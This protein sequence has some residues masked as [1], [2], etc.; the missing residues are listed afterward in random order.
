MTAP[1]SLL[2]LTVLWAIIY[3]PG[4]GD[5][6][7][8]GEEWR[9]TLLGRNMLQNGDWLVPRSGGMPYVAKPPLINW[10][11]AAS[12][13]L[14]GIQNEWTA[15]LPSVLLILSAILGVYAVSRRFMGNNAAFVGSLMFMTSVGVLEKS[16]IAELE[17]YY[18]AFTALAFVF[19][20]AG[21]TG[22]MNRWMGWGT[23]GLFLGL[24][25]ITKGPAHLLFFYLPVVGACWITRRWRELVS[26]PH[27]LGLAI[28]F[29][30]TLA[31]AIPFMEAYGRLRGIPQEAV[32]DAWKQQ[33]ASRV[34]GE[35]KSS[36]SDWIQRGPRALVMFLPWV[37]LVPLCWKRSARQTA[38]PAEPE[39]RIF[40]GLCWGITASFALMILIPSSSARYV[41]PLLGPVALLTGWIFTRA[42]PSIRL[43]KSGA[44]IESSRFVLRACTIIAAFMVTFVLIAHPIMSKKENIRPLGT[45]INEALEPKDAPLYIF[46][47]GQNPYP[48]Y[49][50]ADTV[51]VARVEEMPR[52]GVRWLLLMEEDDRFLPGFE[53]LYG[54]AETKGQFKTTWGA[55]DKQ[56]KPLRLL[57]FPGVPNGVVQ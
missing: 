34:T 57:R 14:T 37:L 6:E 36:L 11:S 30:I 25:F 42:Y 29:G 43:K 17:V 38:F 7:I 21:F 41:A 35:E 52:Q 50:P 16:R 18:I 53:A 5:L 22:K 55:E 27:L 54:P 44:Q 19:W 13:K 46:H 56:G 12:F 49:L 26:L 10:V 45:A 51:E 47:F 23:A 2:I 20:L 4:L 8:K 31:W 24:A 9:R 28:C 48:F 15:R 32:L 33:V 39:R 1:R 3:L 40:A